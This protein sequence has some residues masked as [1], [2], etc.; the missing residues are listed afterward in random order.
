MKDLQRLIHDVEAA[1]RRVVQSVVDLDPEDAQVK[2]HPD[3]WSVN[4]ILEHLVLAECSGISKIWAAA[5]GFRTGKPVWVG[6]HTNRGYSFEEI[7]ARTWK[8]KEIAP[9]ICLPHLGGPL[10]Y[11]AT[12]FRLGEPL[13]RSLS[14]VL[15]GLPL[16]QILFPH[17]ISGPLDAAQRLEF[18]RFHMDRHLEQIQRVK[19]TIGEKLAPMRIAP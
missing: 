7:V 14:Q 5:Q 13:L 11:W 2:P 19:R 3:S 9:S 8:E 12:A 4:E 1:R 16:E 17:F 15:E 18:L 10:A 6:E